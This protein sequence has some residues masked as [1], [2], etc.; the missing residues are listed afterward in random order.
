MNRAKRQQMREQ[1][2]QQ[3]RASLFALLFDWIINKS[4]FGSRRVIIVSTPSFRALTSQL[5]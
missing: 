3:S 1:M 4:A 2:Q 5:S